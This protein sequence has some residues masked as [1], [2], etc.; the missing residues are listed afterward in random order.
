MDKKEIIDS[1][2]KKLFAVYLTAGAG[3][4][5]YTAAAKSDDIANIVV[6]F[7]TGTIITTIIAYFYG[8]S[9][10]SQDKDARRIR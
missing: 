2:F 4:F 8:S 7:A 3:F 5:L 6:G 1:I 10:S 9:Q